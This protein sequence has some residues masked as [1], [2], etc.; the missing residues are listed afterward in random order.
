[1]NERERERY[2]PYEFCLSLQ[3]PS[4]ASIMSSLIGHVKQTKVQ[5]TS[6]SIEIGSNIDPSTA[7]K[8]MWYKHKFERNMPSIEY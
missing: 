7:N 4:W 1:M 5:N 6:Y 2:V 3:S 8:I